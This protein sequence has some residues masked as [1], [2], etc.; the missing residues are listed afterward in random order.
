MRRR[1]CLYTPVASSQHT[2]AWPTNT[3]M[4]TTS[5]CRACHRLD[6]VPTATRRAFAASRRLD[7]H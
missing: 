5:L 3:L 6:D 7:R 4:A 1:A 2:P